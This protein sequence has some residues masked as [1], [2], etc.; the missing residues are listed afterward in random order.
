MPGRND[1]APVGP[2]EF[3]DQVAADEA[4][5]ADH[6]NRTRIHDVLQSQIPHKMN[7]RRDAMP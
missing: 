5:T 4:G 1:N 6:E 2:T 7:M 3:G